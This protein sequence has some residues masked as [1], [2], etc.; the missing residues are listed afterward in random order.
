MFNTIRRR[1]ERIVPNSKSV[2]RISAA[3]SPSFFSVNL[4]VGQAIA[5]PPTATIATSSFDF[6]SLAIGQATTRTMTIQ[7]TGGSDL[8]L[9]VNNI[10]MPAGYRLTVPP[11]DT[12]APGA[13]TTLTVQRN[14]LL[15]TAASVVMKIPTNDPAQPLVSITLVSEAATSANGFEVA[16]DNDPLRAGSLVTLDDT[17]GIASKTIII[18]N[19]GSQNLTMTS[20][21]LPSVFISWGRTMPRICSRPGPLR[22]AI[23]RRLPWAWMPM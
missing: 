21:T 7:N 20:P 23:C 13:T 12:I 9:D 2:V 17:M 4:V 11:A 10:V 5:S 15:A 18:R 1:P 8:T 22:R 16:A 19:M 6:G 14:A 3:G